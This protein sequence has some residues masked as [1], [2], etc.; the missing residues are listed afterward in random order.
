M[1]RSIHTVAV[2]L[3]P[4]LPGGENGGAKIFVLE[5]LIHL[6]SMQPRT[7]FKLFTNPASH[8][9]LM[10]MERPNMS[11][12][13]VNGT[14][15]NIVL[16]S[17]L[18][19]VSSRIFSYCPMRV[20]QMV[21]PLAYQV[22]RW[23]K[24][25][26][27]WSLL[28]K[29]GAD[30][31]FCP[32]TAPIYFELNIPMV[33][34]IYD[35]QY[36]SYPQF[37]EATDFIQ[38]DQTFLEACRKA[39]RLAAISDYTRESV[40]HHGEI[41]ANNIKTIYLR[42]ANRIAPGLELENDVLE[43]LGLTSKRYILYPANFWKHKNHEMLLTA[44][45][46]ACRQGL[47]SDIKLVCTGAPGERQVWLKD[48][49]RRMGLAGR[50]LFPGYLSKEALAVLMSNSCAVVFPSLYE[51]FGLPVIEAMAAGIPVACS[52][53]TSLPEV[54]SDAAILFNPAIPTEIA[55]AIVTLM[56]DHDLRERLIQKG[57][58]RAVYFSDTALMAKEYWALF[59]EAYSA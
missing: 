8:E 13:M 45:S 43:P 30:L 21:G 3:T 17:K 53:I 25:R 19:Y 7:Q 23:L 15:I 26:E 39:T 33:C 40:I 54:A 9:E 49:V 42:M 11:R 47:D 29:M 24:R 20:R 14:S 50:V 18:H 28:R 1:R 35:L 52:N 36:K 57:K 38:R 51:G 46:L 58:A 12:Y 34:T 4:I 55:D 32:F 59:Q 27:S 5:L 2:D 10:F 41:S 31:L 16:R 44:F 56:K 37:F 22:N 48:A 6:A